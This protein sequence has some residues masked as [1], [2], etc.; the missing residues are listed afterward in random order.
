MRHLIVESLIARNL[1]DTSAYYWPGYVNARSNQ[2]PRSIPGQ[3]SGW[4]SLMKG[5]PLTPPLVNA[6]VATPAS[7][8]LPFSLISIIFPFFFLG[9]RKGNGRKRGM[10]IRETELRCYHFFF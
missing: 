1:L 6:L 10:G 3:V 4:S 5:S 2:V 7:R 8:Y 9:E